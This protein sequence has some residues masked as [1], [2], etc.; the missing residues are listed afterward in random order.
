MA[1]EKL[2]LE[3]GSAP[4]VM[5]AIGAPD[6]GKAATKWRRLRPQSYPAN[7]QRRAINLTLPTSV[8]RF[9]RLGPSVTFDTL[10]LK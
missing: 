4:A 3:S 7:Y 8:F 5:D 6:G 9:F 2:A 10:F 1:A